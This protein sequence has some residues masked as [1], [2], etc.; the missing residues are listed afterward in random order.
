VAANGP[1]VLAAA[2]MAALGLWGLSRDSS[3]GN[4]E[5]ATHWAALLSLPQLGHLLAHIDAV[6]GLYYLL[7]HGWAALGASPTTMRIPS[8]IAMIAAVAMTVI[9]G[10]RLTRSAWTGLCAGLIVALTPAISYYAQTAR[11]YA[12]VFACVIGLTLALL[13]A[14]AAQTAGAAGA[15]IARRWLAYGGLVA[16]AGYLNELSLLVL[17]AH[18]VTVLLARYGRRAAAHWAVAAAAGAVAVTPV[19]VISGRETS[20][21]SWIPRPSP[22]TLALL[23]HDYFGVTAAVAAVI[24]GC[25]VVALL[26]PLGARRGRPGGTPAGPG[27]PAEIAWW[28]RGGFTVQ[29]VAT[30]LLVVPA[31]ALILESLVARPFYV[32]RYVL[33]GEAG[34]ALLAA[35]GAYRIGQWLAGQ[36]LADSARRRAL[37][38]VPGGVVCLCALLLQ[39]GPQQFVRTPDSR[40]F[41]FGGPARYV[42]AHARQ[43]DGVLFLGAFYRTARLGYPADFRK[44]SDF[45]LA[46]SPAKSGT[47][48]GTDQPFKATRLLMLA[49]QRIWTVGKSP[50]TPLPAGLMRDEGAVL[51]NHYSLVA[52]R[53]FRGV[54]VTLW[55]R[56]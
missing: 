6:H 56:R 37:V 31:G 51:R 34:A 9:L 27:A 35:A 36:W 25:A 40:L 55:L 1:V 24:I 23:F 11:S 50:V 39:L 44:T 8:V 43:G 22:T 28:R 16:L 26:P 15:R 19:V 12:L 4:D 5:S 53:R 10:R 54:V 48:Q 47:F 42:A 21:V 17:A 41:N 2:T 14:M 18:A 3:M 20:A 49:Q 52:R 33:Y 32:D 38:L 46:V 13:R 45:G 30:P 7:M 29:S